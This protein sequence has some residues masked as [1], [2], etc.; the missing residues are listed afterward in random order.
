MMV[1]RL[2]DLKV[3]QEAR[4]LMKQIYEVTKTFPSEEKYNLVKHL[5][6]CARNIPG[7]IAEGF[8]RYNYQESIQFYRIARG[9]L[10]EI[11]SDIYCSF[12]ANYIDEKIK[13]QILEKI[14]TVNK[15]LN[16]LIA[17]TKIIKA[18]NNRIT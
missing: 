17:K 9:S 13:N 14:E 10:N 18:V 11:K 2:E 16:S 3:W 5:K 1:L 6:E 12:D 7:N 15:M 8:G 4:E